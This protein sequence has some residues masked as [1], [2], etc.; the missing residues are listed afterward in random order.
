MTQAWNLLFLF[1]FNQIWI[2]LADFNNNPQ[3]KYH[4]KSM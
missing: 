4:Q 3:Y 1:V 2:F